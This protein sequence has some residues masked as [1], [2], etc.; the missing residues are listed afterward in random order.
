MRRDFGL[1]LATLCAVVTL[2][3]DGAFAGRCGPFDVFEG[4]DY[5]VS[6]ATGTFKVYQCP[7]GDVGQV[8]VGVLHPGCGVSYFGASCQ[9][10]PGF[11]SSKE[12]MKKDL[13]ALQAKGNYRAPQM[14]K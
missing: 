9:I 5:C 10:S 6:C 1:G 13:D 7:G 11:M 2:S 4:N 14:P 12:N 3:S 8:A